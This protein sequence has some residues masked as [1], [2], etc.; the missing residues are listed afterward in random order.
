MTEDGPKRPKIVTLDDDFGP[1]DKE[2]KPKTKTPTAKRPAGTSL[3]NDIAGLLVYANIMLAPVLKGDVMDDT[4]ILALA[5]AVDEQARKSPRFRKAIDRALVAV[6]GTG[7]IGVCVVIAARRASRHGVISADWDEKLGLALMV[8]QM[9]PSEQTKFM[10]QQMAAMAAAMATAE[11]S[12]G[13]GDSPTQSGS[14]GTEAPRP[15]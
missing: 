2:P 7:L 13:A 12:N 8:G 10:E 14:F 4:E 1:L 6:G 5:K 15:S 3:Q 11:A 9:S